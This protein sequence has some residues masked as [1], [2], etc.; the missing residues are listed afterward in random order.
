[1]LVADRFRTRVAIGL[2]S[3]LLMHCGGRSSVPQGDGTRPLVACN[4]DN[5]CF[6]GNLCVTKA[7]I[8][9]YCRTVKTKTC[10]DGNPCT[11]DLCDPPTGNCAYPLKVSDNDGDGYYGP[12]PGA[13]PGA[14]G[15]CGNDCNDSNA[16][17][18]PGAPEICD[19]LDNNCDGR[20]DEGINSYSL[21]GS[22]VRVTDDT[23]AEGYPDGLVYNGSYFA[24]TFT[25]EKSP[26]A[27]QGYFSGYD[28][29]GTRVVPISSVSQTANNSFGGPL[30]WTGSAFA[31]AWEVHSENAYDIYFNQLD[32]RGKKLGPDVRITNNSG[33]SINPTLFWDGV[34]Y[35][36]AW[37]DQNG[38]ENDP[39]RIYGQKVS[40]DGQLVGTTTAL[41]DAILD[42]RSPILLRSPNA[43][44]LF[45][46]TGNSPNL[47]SQLR[48]RVSAQL[49]GP[50]MSPSGSSIYL[51]DGGV[52]DYTADWVGDRYIV[53]WSTGGQAIGSAIWAASIDTAGNVLQ[54]AQTIT[55]GANF[56]RSPNLLSLGDR[57]ALAWSDDRTT[58]NHYGVRFAVYSP[59]FAALS[60]V[61]TLAETDYPCV[62]PVLASGGSGLA[63]VYTE[64]TSAQSGLSYFLPL[65]C[66]AT[67]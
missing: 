33:F 4:Q 9:G 35:W 46:L 1:M 21:S 58:Y 59:N 27:F 66:G 57:F 28:K 63:L 3:F 13:Q 49:L 56:A 19:G 24:L 12:L 15:S 22:R 51:S 62:G 42:A 39:F 64:L 67:F 17:V 44:M 34:N 25:G 40:T 61:Q 18:H 23:F 6:D 26:S 48:Q 41:T 38:S 20:I 50:D 43:S 5:D 36:I 37:S 29:F 10:D 65:A 53:A 7:C 8:E 32:I 14:S 31:S 2:C 11:S 16:M 47:S 55:F 30:I 45:Y 52:S 60:A 54:V